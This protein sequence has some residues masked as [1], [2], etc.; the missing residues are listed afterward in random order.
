[1]AGNIYIDNAWVHSKRQQIHKLGINEGAGN[2]LALGMDNTCT[3]S[4]FGTPGDEGPKYLA[5]G[6]PHAC[7]AR[8]A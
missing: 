8:L 5:K 2:V 4:P 3:Y 6:V 7:I 1:M